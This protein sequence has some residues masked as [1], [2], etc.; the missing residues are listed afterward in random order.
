M[1]SSAE[2]PEK[3]SVQ[4]SAG[5]PDTG[6]GTRSSVESLLRQLNEQKQA[7][8]RAIHSTQ[9]IEKQ[10]AETRQELNRA[11]MIASVP[12]EPPQSESEGQPQPEAALQTAQQ[13][14]ETERQARNDDRVQAAARIARLEETVANTQAREK[15]ALA[16]FRRGRMLWALVTV[17]LI[18]VAGLITHV[19]ARYQR[20]TLAE[21]LQNGIGGQN[22]V[23]GEGGAHRAEDSRVQES[24]VRTAT[25][26]PGSIAPQEALEDAVAKM[27]RALSA[28]PDTKPEEII[29]SLKK[30]RL[31]V[32]PS[33]CLVAWNEG[34][35]ELLVQDRMHDRVRIAQTLMDCASAIDTARRT[36]VFGRTA[37]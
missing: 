3:A 10:L 15:S 36:M 33:S 34:Q 22:A 7:T 24:R 4:T 16:N 5:E 30:G 8:I 32:D 9:A 14:L 21:A 19:A 26:E 29:E 12:P 17:A 27:S 20:T 31:N 6:A 1:T 37:R 28:Y 11:L 25:G 18:V 35:P 2:A 23:Q 13:Q